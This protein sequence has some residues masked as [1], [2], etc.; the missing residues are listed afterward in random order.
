MY[1]ND[2]F[3]SRTGVFLFAASSTPCMV[4]V[5]RIND[6]IIAKGGTARSWPAATY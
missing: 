2:S 5:Q 1:C 4:P 3:S 6:L